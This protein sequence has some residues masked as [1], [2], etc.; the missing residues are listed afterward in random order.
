MSEILF[1]LTTLYVAYVFYN[2]ANQPKSA[3]RPAAH[4]AESPSQIN[5]LTPNEIPAA[6]I[7][8]N[9]PVTEEAKLALDP[10]TI[11]SVR[12]PLTGEVSKIS[13]NY[14]FTKRWIKE[15]LVSEGLLEKI[16]STGEL[17]EEINE[18]I[19]QALTTLKTLPQYQA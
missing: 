13:S 2:T 18:K 4:K 17:N 16:Y 1:I 10:D 3:S 6:A 9:K 12:N 15:A 5:V 8:E 19:K 11:N 14:P 7:T